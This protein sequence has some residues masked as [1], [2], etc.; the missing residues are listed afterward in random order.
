MNNI[1]HV[2]ANKLLEGTP[3]IV[4]ESEIFVSQIKELL[5]NEHLEQD[6]RI[7]SF[8]AFVAL[9]LLRIAVFVK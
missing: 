5:E 1:H 4:L 2:K 7:D 8:A 9:A 3:I 6:Q